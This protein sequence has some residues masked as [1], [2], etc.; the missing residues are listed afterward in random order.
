[1]DLA[2]GGIPITVPEGDAAAPQI[3]RAPV[4]QKIVAIAVAVLNVA[5]LVVAVMIVDRRKE[6]V[7]RKS[8]PA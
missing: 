6:T 5:V 8:I 1:M 2:P 3:D 4:D 7:H